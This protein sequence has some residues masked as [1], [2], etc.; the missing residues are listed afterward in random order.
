MSRNARH[1][2]VKI[3]LKLQSSIRFDSFKL[4]GQYRLFAFGKQFRPEVLR[5]FEQISQD[6]DYIDQSMVQVW[7][8]DICLLKL[9]KIVCARFFGC[10]VVP[11]FDK[12]FDDKS[13]A[14]Y[15]CVVDE[16]VMD[17]GAN[18][19]IFESHVM[20]EVRYQITWPV[21]KKGC[22]FAN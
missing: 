9:F 6:A 16:A 22:R 7:Q 3:H 21:R 18:A 19:S 20:S 5:H 14:E 12:I 10:F 11:T 13:V 15:E 4:I 2:I 17:F 8:L 1:E